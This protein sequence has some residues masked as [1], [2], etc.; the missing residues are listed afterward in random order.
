[1][2]ERVNEL[3]S[4]VEAGRR[5]QTQSAGIAAAVPDELIIGLG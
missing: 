3:L 5:V 4:A 2:W 1:M